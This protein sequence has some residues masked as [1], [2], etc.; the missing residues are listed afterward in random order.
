MDEHK[1]KIEILSN[2]ELI[3]NLLNK[4]GLSSNVIPLDSINNANKNSDVKKANKSKDVVAFYGDEDYSE[5]DEEMYEDYDEDNWNRINGVGASTYGR[6]GYNAGNACK[7]ANADANFANAANVYACRYMSTNA[8]ACKYMS[9]NTNANAC[10][11][12]SASACRYP[13]NVITPITPLFPDQGSIAPIGQSNNY[14]G[15]IEQKYNQYKDA[16]DIISINTNSEVKDGKSTSVNSDVKENKD[17]IEAYKN[18]LKKVIEESKE[19]KNTIKESKENKNNISGDISDDNIKNIRSYILSITYAKNYSVRT[20]RYVNF[21]SN[22]VLAPTSTLKMYIFLTEQ[23]NVV[24]SKDGD[25]KPMIKDIDNKPI[26]KDGGDGDSKPIVGDGDNKSMVMNGDGDTKDKKSKSE[27]ICYTTLDHGQWKKVFS[28]TENSNKE[29]MQEHKSI[30]EFDSYIQDLILILNAYKD[31]EKL[32]LKDYDKSYIIKLIKDKL[33][34]AEKITG[35]E[36]KEPHAKQIFN[37][38]KFN[39]GT[40]FMND[41]PKFKEIVKKKL[42]EFYF[43]NNCKWANDV[44]CFFFDRFIDE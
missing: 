42:S 15:Y 32:K 21:N 10:K 43:K 25:N 7:F 17:I 44:H 6:M 2:E 29:Y 41:Y 34:H 5:E 18:I 24:D 22:L 27:I 12:M 20:V 33:K 14:K 4:F 23:K 26:I 9:A 8:N 38:L 13:T 35:R 11:Y 31:V 36:N 3:L 39:G 19:N 30:D 16:K 37:T 1:N 28:L 40:R